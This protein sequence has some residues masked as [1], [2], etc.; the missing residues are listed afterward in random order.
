MEKFAQEAEPAQALFIQPV[1]GNSVNH[2]F[3]V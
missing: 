1:N 2:E 3:G